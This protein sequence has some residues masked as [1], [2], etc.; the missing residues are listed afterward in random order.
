MTEN[1]FEAA[2]QKLEE[3]EKKVLAAHVA[4]TEVIQGQVSGE[5]V[6]YSL[7]F[8]HAQDTIMTIN[9]ELRIISKLLPLFENMRK[10]K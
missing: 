2:K 3:A 6:E 9:S 4:Q 7:L 1:N 5:D 10:E 8:I